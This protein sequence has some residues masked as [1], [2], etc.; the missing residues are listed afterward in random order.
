MAINIVNNMIRRYYD[1]ISNIHLQNDAMFQRH[2]IL[3]VTVMTSQVDYICP[4]LYCTAVAK[5]TTA[6][7]RWFKR[8]KDIYF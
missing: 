4:V 5:P 6:C 8:L 2:H 3:N 7:C 1:T